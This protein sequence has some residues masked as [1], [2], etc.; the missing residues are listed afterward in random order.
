VIGEDVVVV[1]AELF[2]QE[3]EEEE[4]SG[5]LTGAAEPPVDVAGVRMSVGLGRGR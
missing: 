5:E 4:V 2:V 1:R 3:G